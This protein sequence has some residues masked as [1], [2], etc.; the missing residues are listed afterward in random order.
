VLRY[1]LSR[2][3]VTV[4]VLVTVSLLTFALTQAA[5]DPAAGLAGP[6][7]TARDIE[8]LRRQHGLDR[9]WPE[10]YLA[11]VGRV[12]TGD[13]G[14]SLHYK[15]P[16][17]TLILERLPTTM[18]LAVAAIVAALLTAVPLGIAAALNPGGL[19]DR[20]TLMLAVL[21]QALPS[22]WTG[23]MLIVLFGVQLGWLPI[24]GAEGPEHF[25]MPT[26][27]LAVFSLPVLLRLTRAGM[28]DVMSADY[29]RAARARGLLP[30]SIVWKHAL[31]NA[32]MP[33]VAVAA[34]QFG[35]LLGGSI[36][37]EQLFAMHG[38]GYLAWQA[39]LIGDAAVVQAIVLLMA[40]IYA[41]L[42]FA[43]DVLNALFD[44]RIRMQGA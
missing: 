36:V 19:V 22:F 32:V 4:A 16:V 31:R 3:V 30:R 2:L 35:Y 34:V 38:V 15:Q 1:A 25:V 9:P 28:I 8:L 44:P 14:Q 39:I 42:T 5:V 41:V 7:A 17:L 12:A 11:W 37:T 23:L 40:L 10:R 26:I 27:T 20:F 13:L 18:I 43:A 24:S 6:D 29:I 21:G 33:L